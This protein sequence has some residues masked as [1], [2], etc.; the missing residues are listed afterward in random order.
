MKDTG[1]HAGSND[2]AFIHDW[3]S[4]QDLKDFWERHATTA[5]EFFTPPK[6][7]GGGSYEHPHEHKIEVEKGAI[8][9]EFHGHYDVIF[10][11]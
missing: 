11:L 7:E 3:R 6:L 1:D 5:R 2:Y 10:Q 4:S 9:L 8:Q